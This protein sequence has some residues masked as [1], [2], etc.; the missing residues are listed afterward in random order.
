MYLSSVTIQE[1]RIETDA[2]CID[3]IIDSSDSS[4]LDRQ[5]LIDAIK[6]AKKTAST[7]KEELEKLHVPE[8]TKKIHELYKQIFAL[9]IQQI[10]IAGQILSSADSAK[11][12]EMLKQLADIKK[13][14]ETLSQEIL[15]EKR[16]LS[17]S[18]QEV[19]LPEASPAAAQPNTHQSN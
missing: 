3:K 5:A 6:K 7:G 14:I 9:N 2:K 13:Q 16:A 15:D 1:R 19:Q 12:A 10:D 4:T 8:S 18:Y 11:N 17:A